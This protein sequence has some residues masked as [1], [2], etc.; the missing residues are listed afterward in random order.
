MPEPSPKELLDFSITLAKQAGE[1]IRAACDTELQINEA[2]Q[3]D[4][5]IQLD[6]DI[7]SFLEREILAR[8]PG[9]FI[10][11]EEGGE[12]SGGK[13]LEW[14]IDPID[15][16]V[17][18]V[19][20]I[21]HFCVSIATRLDDVIQTGVIYDPMRDECFHTLKGGGAFRNGNPIHVSQRSKLNESIVAL[22][23]SKEAAT[24][25]K[26]LTLYQF[27]S[28]NVRKLRALGSAALDM[29]YIASGRMDAYIEQ[30]IK[31]W[32]IASGQL[33]I[34]ESGGK[35]ELTP[36]DKPHHFHIVASNGLLD[37]SKR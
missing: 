18:L 26:C 3:H 36:L 15:G 20:G 8:Y 30:G 2:Y 31:I 33:L 13:G 24:V 12:G 21:P 1:K 10:L 4:L 29:A 14:I 7:Q 5:K 28:R 16:T 34:E 6:V 11:G 22:G 9:H 23:F 17:N 25:E 19:Y 37:L 35:V 27:Y 32:D